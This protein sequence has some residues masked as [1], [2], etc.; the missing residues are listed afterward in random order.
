MPGSIFEGGMPGVPDSDGFSGVMPGLAPDPFSGSGAGGTT[1]AADTPTEGS[2]ATQTASIRPTVILM[3]Y[4]T[5][6]T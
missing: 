3:V 4:Y 1:S 6:T 2:I 5:A